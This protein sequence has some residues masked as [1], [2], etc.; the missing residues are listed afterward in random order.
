MFV[1]PQQTRYKL[2]NFDNL[3][4][5]KTFLLFLIRTLTTKSLKKDMCS[6]K[7]EKLKVFFYSNLF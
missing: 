2:L 3:K 4:I 7:L 1:F 5:I 6:F